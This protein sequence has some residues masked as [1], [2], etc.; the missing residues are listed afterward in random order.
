MKFETHNVCGRQVYIKGTQT[1]EE[2]SLVGLKPHFLCTHPLREI[3]S[4][5]VRICRFILV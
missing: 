2:M 4:L 5:A 1:I 3:Y